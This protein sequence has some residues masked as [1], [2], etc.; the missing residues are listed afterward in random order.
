MKII[1]I[2]R[3]YAAHARELENE[4]PG[5]PVVFLKP[6]TALP[7]RKS[8]FFLPAFAKKI[9]YEAE[10]V[11]RINRNGKNIAE[12]FAKKYFSEITV[13]IDFTARDLQEEMQ[14]KGLPWERAKAFDGSA[15]VGDFV[16]VDS[17]E[18]G[19]GIRFSLKLNGKTVQEGNSRMMLFPFD[20]IIASVSSFITL[21]EGDLVFTGT[22]A[23]VGPVK[24]GDRLEAYLEDRKVLTV[25][26]R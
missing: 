15:P 11:L 10:L 3:N 12:R 20:R 1:C 26:V 13:G 6:D 24:Y 9:H 18:P 25:N 14:K 4:V 17:L 16:P 7:Q 21:K 5:E 23:G 19:N 8:P 2:G 22:P